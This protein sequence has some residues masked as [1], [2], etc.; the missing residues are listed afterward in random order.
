[1]RTT[2]KNRVNALKEYIRCFRI[3][4][5]RFPTFREMLNGCEY[6]SRQT[7]QADIRRLIDEGFLVSGEHGRISF[8]DAADGIKGNAISVV[9]SVRCG[10][11]TEAQEEVEGCVILPTA[12]FGTDKNLVLLRAK[13]DSMKDRQIS[14]GD[15]LVVRRQSSA[16]VGDIVIALLDTG[17]TT[18]KILRK[19]DIGNYYLEAA[20]SE[21]SD[22]HPEG[23]WCIYGVVRQAIHDFL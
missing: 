21:Y 2:D 10:S 9:G 8:S 6:V 15:L 18:C 4:Y 5:D 20:N 17:E 11:P 22:I 23:T 16:D 1:M 14:D 7:L 12:I 19:D 13:G 3:D